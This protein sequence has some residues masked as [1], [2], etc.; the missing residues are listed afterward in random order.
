MQIGFIGAGNMA[1]AIIG[2]L[3]KTGTAADQVSIY[4]PNHEL[5]G[6]L[7]SSLG[8]RAEQSNTALFESC[9]VIVLA[10]KPQVMKAALEGVQGV[11]LKEGAFV[12]SV[13]AGIPI[14]MMQAWLGQPVPLSNFSPER[15]SG[16][17]QPAQLNAP[18]RFS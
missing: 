12:I 14:A 3:L 4:E 17:L 16:W 18:R 8:I 15:N 2:G 1:Q 9:D 10:V 13:A 7:V 5:A 11:T 6:Q